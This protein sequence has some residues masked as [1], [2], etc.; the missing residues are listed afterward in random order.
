ML[1]M[2]DKGKIFDERRKSE[3]RKDKND[4]M[5]NF[6]FTSSPN[7]RL[8]G[9]HSLPLSRSFDNPKMV[10]CRRPFFN[11]FSILGINAKSSL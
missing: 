3:R 11:G 10:R 7:Y 1:A 4:E 6:K 5:W 8:V 9:K 2:N